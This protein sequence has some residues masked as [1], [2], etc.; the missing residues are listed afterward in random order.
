MIPNIP[1]QYLMQPLDLTVGTEEKLGVIQTNAAQNPAWFNG[2]TTPEERAHVATYLITHPEH[3][4]WEVWR[5]GAF[6]GIVMLW[7]ITPKSDALLHFAFADR[8][9]AGKAALL[10]RFCRYCFEDLGF[11]RLSMEVPEYVPTL[12]SFARRKLAFKFEG[13]GLDEHPVERVYAE[14][15]RVKVENPHLWIASRGSRRERAHWKAGEWFDLICLRLLASEYRE[16]Y[17][18]V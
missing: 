3:L 11:Q 9:L 13:E 14:P 4:T 12:V 7:R 18:E 8:Y 2:P 10:R 6:V 17:P 1:D 5:G 15:S 16:H